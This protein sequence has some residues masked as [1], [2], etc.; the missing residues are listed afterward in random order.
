MSS[1]KKYQERL[2]ALERGRQAERKRW[3]AKGEALREKTKNY[4]PK[5]NNIT[6]SK[7]QVESY[8]TKATG[9][10]PTQ[11]SKADKKAGRTKGRFLKGKL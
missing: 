8:A 10:T 4:K 1:K 7:K 9:I 5:D 11:G 2:E 6:L 3:L